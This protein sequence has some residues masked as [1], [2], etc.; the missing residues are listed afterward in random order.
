MRYPTGYP[1]GEGRTKIAVAFPTGVFNRIIERAQKEKKSFNDMT[2]EL[3]KLGMF[4]LDES[5]QH[6]EVTC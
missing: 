3:C 2:V 5:D 6:E 1:I 4:D